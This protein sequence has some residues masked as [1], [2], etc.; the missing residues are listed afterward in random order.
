MVLP[1]SHASV[2]FLTPFP[3][4]LRQTEGA[5][6]QVYPALIVLEFEQ[7]SVS[8]VLLS[9]QASGEIMTP[10]IDFGLQVSTVVLVP[11]EQTQVDKTE[12]Q[13][14]AHP[15]PSV[16]VPSSQS[17]GG[18]LTELPQMSH[19]FGLTVKLQ[20]ALVSMAHMFEHPSFIAKL[21][22]SQFST[23]AFCPSP[24]VV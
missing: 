5:P 15:Y 14:K 4:V 22:S 19:W 9:S 21:P 18:F 16:L 12:R 13:S 7:P 23:K 17:S 8:I 1:S 6:V 3:H 11:P 24:Q 10:S 2:E 20:L